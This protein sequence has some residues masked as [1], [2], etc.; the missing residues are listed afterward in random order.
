[1][2]LF[3]F[4]A[5]GERGE[6]C[7]KAK[8]EVEGW[9]RRAKEKGREEEEKIKKGG[10]RRGRWVDPGLGEQCNVSIL[11]TN[12]PFVWFSVCSSTIQDDNNEHT[13]Y[14]I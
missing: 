9:E 11:S 3:Y 13:L 4:H 14:F 12:S 6:E 1:M 10:R 8:R 7:G 5:E 2:Y